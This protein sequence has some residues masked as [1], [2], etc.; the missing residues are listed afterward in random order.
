MWADRHPNLETLEVLRRADRVGAA[1]HLTVAVVPHV[2][3]GMEPGLADG[4]THIS[5]EWAV[6]RRPHLGV[7]L[8]DEA[9]AID[10]GDGDVGRKDE[11]RQ[12]EHLDGAGAQLRKHVGVA[13][14]LAVWKQLDLHSPARFLLDLLGR[15][16]QP[17]VH[18]MGGDVVVGVAE[19]ELGR[20]A[21]PCEDAEARDARDSARRPQQGA[22]CQSAHPAYPHRLFIDLRPH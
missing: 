3:E 16:A 13:T 21:A 11:A 15:L 4:A 7:V 12:V 17:H 2:V 22:A 6:H 19:H 18:R 8:E 9:D 10:R 1:C 5:A 20:I 14:E